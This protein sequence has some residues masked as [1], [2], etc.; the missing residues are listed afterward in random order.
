M[1]PRPTFREGLNMGIPDMKEENYCTHKS[2]SH[3]AVK[4]AEG[5]QVGGREVE[6]HLSGVAEQ[7]LQLVEHGLRQELHHQLLRPVSRVARR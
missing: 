1:G 2:C 7:T 5:V 3:D 6:R 4:V